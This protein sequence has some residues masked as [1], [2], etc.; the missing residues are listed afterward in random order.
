MKPST[1]N[2]PT[3]GATRKA[4]GTWEPSALLSLLKDLYDASGANRDFIQARCLPEAAGEA[5]LASY[6]AKVKEPFFP[7]R[8]EGQLKLGE[9]RKAI[10]EYRKATG[11]VAGV[12][13]LQMAYV[14]YGVEYT[15]EYGD[16]DERFYISIETVLEEFATLLREEGRELYSS[17][18]GR[19]AALERDTDGIGWGFHDA[20]SG[21]VYELAHDFGGSD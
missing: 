21:I 14:E 3:W 10:R 20:I 4:L 9:A 11:N 8:G 17:F 19:L 16:I 15:N 5:V 6:R 2:R 18:K 12:A 13:E 1:K 7:K